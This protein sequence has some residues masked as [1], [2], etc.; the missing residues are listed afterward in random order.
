MNKVWMQR[1]AVVC[2]VRMEN[3]IG[4]LVCSSGLSTLWN[5]EVC[6]SLEK[7]RNRRYM[8]IEV[9]ENLFSRSVRK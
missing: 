1:I 5:V 3:L 2:L 9:E 8:R 6:K 7:E 4:F